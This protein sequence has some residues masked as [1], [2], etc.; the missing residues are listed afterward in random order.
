MPEDFVLLILLF[1]LIGGVLVTLLV[2]PVV[3]LVRTR[4]IVA[5]RQRLD[6]LEAELRALRR[7]QSAIPPARPES[8][9]AAQAEEVLPVEPVVESTS[10]PSPAPV[11]SAPS[12][13]A[14][15]TT[16]SSNWLDARS[17]EAWIGRRGLGWVAVFLLFF[18]TA[19][20]LKYA[21]DNDWI[22]PLGQVAIGVL[23]GGALTVAGWRF[24][25]R[26]WRRFSQMLT[27]AGV[28][29]LYLTS[30]SAF[31]FYRLLPSGHASGYLIAIVVEGLF[32]AMFYE[33]PAIALV[34]VIGALL[35]PILL[36]SDRD[37]YRNLFTYLTVLNAGVLSLTY[38]RPWPAIA[39]VSLV[40][41]H[42]LFWL[43]FDHHYHPEK[44]AAAIGFLALVWVLYLLAGSVDALWR[45]RSATIEALSRFLLNAG[46]FGW[47]AYVMLEDDWQSWL[48]TFAVGLA[49]IYALLGWVGLTR[50]A[51]IR[52][53]LLNV[54][55]ALAL[56]ALAIPLQANAEWIAVGWAIQGAALWWF[57][58]RIRSRVFHGYGAALQLVAV[59]RVIF[60]DTPWEGREP[61]TPLLNRYAIPALVVAA[62]AL[63]GALVSR[64]WSG[65]LGVGD[66]AWTG[67]A[68]LM[69]IGLIWLIFS[70]ETYTY[71]TSRKG[72]L[73]SDPPSLERSGQTALSIVWAAYA[74]LL[75]TMGFRMRS[76]PIRWAALGLFALTLAKVILIDMSGL[77]GLY[78]VLAFLVLALVMGGAAWGY[79][80][81]QR[82]G[83]RDRG[84][85]HATA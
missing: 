54:S 14:I 18:A 44:R 68:G 41:T 29:L 53:V 56:V 47:A 70:V 17:L 59:L 11:H 64:R 69:G 79:Q 65:R 50:K 73:G 58:L 80:K 9:A 45:R 75:L 51:D 15:Q 71:F 6:R 82:W 24:H 55:L 46:L 57:G 30:F 2:L 12:R 72:L 7:M 85:S 74:A 34:A 40:G 67:A 28:I 61:F 84:E 13:P 76:E 8:V 78:R 10:R 22:G 83:D 66:R 16:P 31:G 60:V 4:S 20:F 26:G 43:W 1:V 3:A 62:A 23:A 42:G 19:F 21:F 36:H 25:Q 33:A 32:L 27:A 5:L 52:F 37:Q 35:T 81:F 38:F 48:G 49:V 63:A 39:T 77:P